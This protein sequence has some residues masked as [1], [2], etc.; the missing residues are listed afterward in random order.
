MTLLLTWLFPCGIIMGADSIA[1]YRD[2]ETG[3]IRAFSTGIQKVFPIP[4]IHSGVSF[5]GNAQV[6][7]IDIEEWMPKFISERED[8]YDTIHDFSIILRDEISRYTLRITS[9]PGTHEYRYGNRGIHL[10][11]HVLHNKRM[12]PTF[13]HIHNGQSETTPGIDPGVVNANHDRPPESVLLDWRKHMIPYTRNGDFLRF[14]QLFDSLYTN[15]S[16]L[17]VQGRSIQFPEPSKY[18]SEIEAYSDFVRFWIRLTRDIYAMSD[19]PEII[20]G[21][22]TI[23]AIKPD[24]ECHLSSRA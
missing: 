20:G 12:V 15:I 18:E 13:Y 1:T 19:M 8:D 10:A 23:L 16:N 24:G 9:A 11:G 6:G 21:E 7:L 4:K 3:E 14:A 5:W 2:R 17:R 22:I